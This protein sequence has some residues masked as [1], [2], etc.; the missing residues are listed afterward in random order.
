M[1]SVFP[2]TAEGIPGTLARGVTLLWANTVL[3]PVTH[4][5]QQAGAWA[6][7]PGRR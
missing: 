4:S 1:D 3:F 2:D 6:R 5:R 7:Q